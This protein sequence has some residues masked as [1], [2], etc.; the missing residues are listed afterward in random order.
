[1]KI[2]T[3]NA[4]SI[5]SRIDPVRNWLAD[6]RPD[7]LAIQETKVQDEA[8]PLDAF[9][10]TGYHVIFRGEKKYNGVALFSRVEPTNIREKLPGDDED[11]ARFLQADYNGITVVNTY[12]P[13]G[14]DMAS[15]KFQYKL[16][17]LG[18][19]KDYFEKTF[20]PDSTLIWLGDLNVAR[21]AIDVHDPKKLW[22][23]VCYC[24]EVQDAL[25]EVM[26][27]GLTDLF[28]L[29]HPDQPGL[30]TFWDY[31]VP[32]GFKRN[33]GWRIDYINTTAPLAERCRR[34]EVD[35]APRSL[36]KPSDHTFLWAELDAV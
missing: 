22:G 5:R 36:E 9:A 19:L 33:I 12:V 8:F 16:R 1:M 24:Q 21:Q 27:L 35:T 13:Q 28:R 31:R 20:A 26:A 11:E 34:C 17:W 32:N 15:E 10:D 14:R 7:V 23:S 30:Y 18:L 6:H 25:E 29:H 3:F 4:N 2:A